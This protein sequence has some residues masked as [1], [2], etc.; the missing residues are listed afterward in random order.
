MKQRAPGGTRSVAKTISTSEERDVGTDYLPGC[1]I[2]PVLRD[3]SDVLQP[4]PVQVPGDRTAGADAVSGDAYADRTLRQIAD[5]QSVS[6]LSRFLSQSPWSAAEVAG[7]WIERFQK[8]MVGQV[9]AEHERQRR[10]R[11]KRQGHPRP[12]VVVGYLIGDDSTQHKP[13]GKKMSGLGQHYSTTAEQQVTGHSLV[14]SLYVLLGRR[15][16]LAPQ[17]YRQKAVCQREDVPFQS[18][19][20][21]MEATIRDFQ[22]VPDTLT[23][24][25]VD[26]W[27]PCKRI[28]HTARERGFLITSGLKANRWLWVMNTQ[29]QGHW[30]RLNEYAAHLALS[31]DDLA[32]PG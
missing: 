21:M 7:A 26:S 11:P 10:Q 2:A 13:K 28:W 23:H 17:M 24:V 18:K 29:G 8:Q 1:A 30:M 16:P 27:Y 22:P 14:Q 6:G 3:V 20:D 15:C 31:E 5:G 12:T 4:T 19:V 32:R 25:L 9:K